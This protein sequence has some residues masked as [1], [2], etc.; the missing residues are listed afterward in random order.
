VNKALVLNRLGQHD[1]AA[2]IL[3]DLALDPNIPLDIEQI[4]KVSLANITRSK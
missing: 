3:G 2:T 4:A 1:V